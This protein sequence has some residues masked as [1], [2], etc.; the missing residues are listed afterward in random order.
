MSGPRKLCEADRMAKHRSL[1]EQRREVDGWRNSGVG[2]ARYAARRG[3]S[4]ASLLS[5]A[6]RVAL[7]DEAPAKEVQFVRLA[8]ATT[9]A[10]PELVVEVGAARIA[11]ARGFDAEHLRNVIA[12]LTTGGTK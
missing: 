11:V 2:A 1:G 9:S 4:P 8:V 10:A 7:A 5:W 12:A 6:R 3:Y